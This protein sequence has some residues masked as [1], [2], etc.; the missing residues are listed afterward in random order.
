MN[1][2]T[3][4]TA[5]GISPKMIRYYEQIGLL[6][7]TVRTAAGYR[8][9]GQRELRTL[10]F[11]R[12]ARALG[13]SVNDIRDLLALWQDHRRSSA[14]VKQIAQAHIAALTAKAAALQEM[15][16][17]LEHLADHCQGD[18]RPDCPI[19]DAL[20]PEATTDPS[21]PSRSPRTGGA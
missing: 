4:A 13:F 14:E 5:S 3:A 7:P 9:Y 11:I 18:Q 21:T 2:G 6:G 17:S 16:Q 19:L 8:T 10:A 1:I 12:R 15:A 20:D